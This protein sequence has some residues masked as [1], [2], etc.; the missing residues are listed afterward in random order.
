M[1][2]IPVNHDN[3]SDF[4]WNMCYVALFLIHLQCFQLKEQ[5]FLNSWLCHGFYS[6]AGKLKALQSSFFVCCYHLLS[7]PTISQTSIFLLSVL[8]DLHITCV[9][10]CGKSVKMRHY[11]EHLAGNCRSHYEDLNSPSKVTLQD[12]LDKPSSSI[13]IRSVWWRL[14]EWKS[15]RKL[16]Y[17]NNVCVIYILWMHLQLRNRTV[18]LFTTIFSTAGFHIKGKRKLKK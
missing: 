8:N 9:R 13:C 18:R 1:L 2:N 5:T 14:K 4:T 16:N 12:V 10:K 7:S 11:Q 15:S 3:F 6:T 17:C